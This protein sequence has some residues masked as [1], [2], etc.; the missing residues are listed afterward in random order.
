VKN[1]KLWQTWNR[2]KPFL[3]DLEI[4][5][6]DKNKEIDKYFHKIGIRKIELV[7]EKQERGYSF[8]FKLNG[9]K[10]FVMGAN[11]VPPSLTYSRITRQMLK[12]RLLMAKESG[13]MMLRIWGGGI[14]GDKN[15]YEL[16]DEMGI[17][18]WQDFMFACAIYP[19]DKYFLD[20]VKKEAEYWVKNL[21]NHASL[22]IWVG[23][24]EVDLT[25]TWLDKDPELR[26]MNIGSYTDNKINR[27]ILKEVCKKYDPTRFYLSSSPSTP[28]GK[29]YPDFEYDGD[30]HFWGSH[31]SY[32]KCEARFVSEFGIQSSASLDSVRKYGFLNKK[33]DN[34]LEKK[35]KENEF[36]NKWVLKIKEG[37]K[38]IEDVIMDSQLYQAHRTKLMIEL[39]RI[40]KEECG[41]V[42][43]WKFNGP[44]ADS[45]DWQPNL[46]C[47]VDY[48]NQPKAVFYFT[49]KAYG[50]EWVCFREENNILSVWLSTEEPSSKRYEVE[51][52][53]GEFSGKILRKEKFSVKADREKSVKIKDYDLADSALTRDK[54]FYAARLMKNGKLTG[55]NVYYLLDIGK[56]YDLKLSESKLQINLRLERENKIILKLACRKFVRAARLYI[57]SVEV[58][59]SDN[60]F[61]IIPGTIKEVSITSKENTSL[62]G[63]ML[64]VT[65]INSP[66]QVVEVG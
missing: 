61:D 13:N 44:K 47:A 31:E 64:E 8:Y 27:K 25:Y 28:S 6:K 57:P 22:A 58:N 54:E 60:F 46:C 50:K 15:F 62:K 4:V 7:R 10:I 24:N 19:Q 63:K 1:P 55:E 65:A 56:L 35:L 59:Y 20:L 41:G 16:C 34:Y 32:I 11:W 37:D 18:V 40:R 45:C 3:Y 21:R 29:G 51:I 38:G 48:Y 26:Q 12:E 30:R 42:L 52:I 43:Y 17:L 66:D 53:R 33:F 49:K 36:R 23:D 2:G 14:Y 9:E 39:Q 5:L